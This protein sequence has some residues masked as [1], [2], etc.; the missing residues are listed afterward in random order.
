MGVYALAFVFLPAL[1]SVLQT[2]I[3]QAGLIARDIDAPLVMHGLNTP[4]F[5]VYARRVVEKRPPLPGEIVLTQ[6]DR[7]GELPPHEVLFRSKHIVLLRTL[8]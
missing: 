7:L 3:K 2:P 8:P 5:G 1:G 4:S 6:A